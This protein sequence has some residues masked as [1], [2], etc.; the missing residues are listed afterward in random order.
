MTFEKDLEQK[1]VKMV[2]RSLGGLCL[3]WVCPGWAGVPDRIC[4][5]PGGRIFFVEMKR[6]G[7]YTTSRQEWWRDRLTAL[8]FNCFTVYDSAGIDFIRRR[9]EEFKL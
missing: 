6:P 9:I 3:K 4:L 1:L 2:E 7:G 8:G 5:L